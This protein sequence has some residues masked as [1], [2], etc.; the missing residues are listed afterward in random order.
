M[1]V[2]EAWY[3]AAFISE[4]STTPI[5]RRILGDPILLVL[6]AAG[7]PHALSDRCPHRFAPLHMGRADGQTI[8]CPYHGLRFDMQ[9][10]C[11]RNPH[12][13]GR[14]PA[15]AQVRTYPVVVRSAV[16]WLWMGQAAGADAS[17]IPDLQL[18]ER[19][20]KPL[21]HGYLNMRV[22]YRLVLDNLLDLSHAQ[23]LHRGTLSPA[24]AKRNSQF[25]AQRRSV[26]VST[27]MRDVPTPTSQAYYFAGLRGD[28]YSDME[29]KMPSVLR[30]RLVMADPGGDP[31]RGSI[32]RNAHLITPETATSTHYFWLHSRNQLI[33][34][35]ETDALVRAAISNAF[36]TEDEPM[37]AA[38]QDYMDGADFF[39]LQPLYLQSDFAGAR[40]RRMLEQAV[41]RE[42]SGGVATS[43][44]IN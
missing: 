22:D 5:A 3:C 16:V 14:I 36:G 27:V 20:R 43:A 28:Y 17:L 19:T 1:F 44:P 25:D 31:E 41:A 32:T 38:V 12:G 30:Q 18:I 10:A 24:D 33:E 7:Q 21:V 15:A 9:G 2:R 39:A 23:Y 6:D 34:D 42:A 26:K 4:L 40:V 11:V 29:W 13:D 8:E 35:E 37:I